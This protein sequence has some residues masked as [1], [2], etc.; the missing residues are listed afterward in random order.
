MARTALFLLAFVLVIT[1]ASWIRFHGLDLTWDDREDE[2]YSWYR[3]LHGDEAVQG[4]KLGK[5]F[6]KHDYVYRPDDLHGPFLIYSTVPL[7]WLRGET[8][9]QTLSERTLR[10]VPVL[11]G[12]GL[13]VLLWAWRREMGLVPMIASGCLIAISPIM[14]FYSRYYIMEMPMVF[15]V[16]VAMIAAWRYLQKPGLLWAI[17]FGV[18]GGL[19]HA[20]KETGAI[21]FLTMAL[22]ALALLLV[23]RSLLK[24]KGFAWKHLWWSLGLGLFVSMLCF[25]HFFKHPE[26]IWESVRSYFL[27]ADRAEGKGHQSPWWTYLKTLAW[28]RERVGGP[29]WS[30]AMTLGLGCLGMILAFTPWVRRVGNPLFW[31][32]LALYTLFTAVIYSVVPYKTPWSMVCW[33]YTL[34]LMAGLTVGILAQ[35]KRPYWI[36]PILV[37]VGFAAGLWNLNQQTKNSLTRFKT[38]RRNP[39]VYAH[40]SFHVLSLVRNVFDIAKVHPDGKDLKIALCDK[41]VGWPLP[42]YFREFSQLGIARTLP[43]ERKT[44]LDQDVIIITPAYRDDLLAVIG[45]THRLDSFYGIRDTTKILSYVK[46]DLYEKFLQSRD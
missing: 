17:V 2:N 30:E 22:A 45:D 41:D 9:T 34:M 35:V 13:I 8:T 19:T 29:I 4:R 12:L 31:R 15:L 26:A 14:V 21:S 11:Y 7:A 6:D 43:D 10:T 25:S 38:D 37:A 16:T 1:G 44:L 33:V 27:Y 40:T 42:W 24:D 3:P 28:N 36:V 5:L 46:K 23:N 32:W 20:T 39:F 18:A